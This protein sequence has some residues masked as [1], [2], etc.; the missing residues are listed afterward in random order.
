MGTLPIRSGRK[1]AP[2]LVLSLHL[3]QYICHKRGKKSSLNNSKGRLTFDYRMDN[4]FVV[5]DFSL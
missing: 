2:L 1:G 4:E 3:V 5:S